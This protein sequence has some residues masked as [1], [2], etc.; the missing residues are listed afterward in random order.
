MRITAFFAR[1]SEK[2]SMKTAAL[3]HALALAALFT[4]HLA[5]AH[6]LSGVRRAL[7]TMDAAQAHTVLSAIPA[8]ELA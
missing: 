6:E 8:F 5:F 2:R 4:T 7:Q 1:D 3:I